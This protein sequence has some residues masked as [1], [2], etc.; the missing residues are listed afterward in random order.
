MILYARIQQC[1][2]RTSS[3]VYKDSIYIC[4]LLVQTSYYIWV[5]VSER[6]QKV[7]FCTVS[8]WKEYKK[9]LF[10]LFPHW[11]STKS[12]FLYSLPLAFVLPHGWIVP[13]HFKNTE[14]GVTGALSNTFIMI[15]TTVSWINVFPFQHV[16]ISH[17]YFSMFYYP[18]NRKTGIYIGSRTR[19]AHTRT[20]VLDSGLRPSSSTKSPCMYSTRTKTFT[21]RY[22][23]SYSSTHTGFINPF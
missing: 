8:V 23:S 19:L 7:I 1:R 13:A 21:Y 15:F 10:V 20:L 17:L 11:N 2:A 9:S 22:V 12:H 5:D 14:T 18:G 16:I 6:V 3:T 4:Q